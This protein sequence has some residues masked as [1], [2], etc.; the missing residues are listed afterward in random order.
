MTMTLHRQSDARF[1]GKR[2]PLGQLMLALYGLGISGAGLLAPA[3]AQAQAETAAAP[4][5]DIQEVVVTARKRSETLIEVPVSIQSFSDKDLRAAGV[6][7]IT[8]LTT[9]S[10][11]SFTSAQ[12]NGAQ[13]RAF[14]VMT[15]R[16]L[17]GELN[18]PWENSGGV[19]ID[20]I[21]IS[22]GVGSIGMNDVAR[23]EVL[24]GP[25]N[26]FFGR[27]TFG[28]AVNFITKNPSGSL[29]GSVNTM[30]DHH[31]SVDV[32]ATIEGPLA[33]DLA[34]GRLSF[35]SSNKA[36]RFRASDGGA[37]GAEST[38]FVTGTVYLTPTDD[39]WLRLRGHFQKDDDSSPATAM[40]SSAGNTSCTGKVYSGIDR[41]GNRVDYT[42]GT[43]YFCDGIPTLKSQGD[44]AI[45]ANTV[46]PAAAYAAFVNN[47]L[48]DPFLGTVPR[49]DHTGMRRDI[50][51]LSAQLGYALPRGMDLAVNLGFNEAG[52]YSIYDLDRTGVN[53][54][55]NAQTNY[56]KDMTLDARIS[57]D[58]KAALRALIGASYFKAT[59]QLSQL[60][61]NIGLGVI[62][63]GRNAGTFVNNVSTVPALY[64]SV[65][66]DITKTVTAS[67]ETRY[68]SDTVDFTNFANTS[69]TSNEKKNWLP[70]VSLRYKP[71][72]SLSTYV[73]L[74]S[75]VQPL[76]VN[77]G[78]ANASAAGK[79]YIRTLY[80][81]ADDF[82]PQPKLTSFEIGLKQRV[83]EKLIYALALYD[84]KWTDRLSITTL[85]NPAAC[86]TGTYS[87]P[88]CP[89]S[90]AGSQ[91]SVGN[92][93][94]LR[95]LELSIDSQLTPQLSAGAYIDVKRGTW[96]RFDSG[97]QSRFGSNGVRALTGDAVAFDGNHMARIPD[98][99]VAANATY[100]MGLGGGWDSYVRGDVTYV[101]KQWETDFNFTQ[102]NAY[103]RVDLRVGFEKAGASIEFFVRNLADDQNWTS[104][105]RSP[106]LGVTPLTSF[107]N[108]GLIATAQDA[109]AYGLRLRYAF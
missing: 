41:D 6:T 13:G 14:G 74:A 48:N 22:G 104:I 45:N 100:R 71:S 102:A 5:M 43:A 46:I 17:Q 66:Y 70:R 8:D 49:L 47:A 36:A 21:F 18:Y 9:K 89:L 105:T 84:Q 92:Q 50:Q 51:R 87:T 29:K 40:V 78:Y 42:P 26:A 53:N 73:T 12:G 72:A 15:F 69:T 24:K 37:L 54:L 1:P 20:G 34:T 63:P 91:V 107:S 81:S 103:S 64:G 95:G 52:Q 108:M 57:T 58:A 7:E 109:R 32:D 65:E 4:A 98:I 80:P 68:Q 59:Y 79:A 55:M 85:F 82:T 77:G 93:A 76:T 38:R 90:A 2:H 44:G 56:T 61:Y 62:A 101:G 86:G 83:S 27:S 39:L 94:R 23:V 96:D 19:F 28:G 31:G 60:D 106:N 25:Q 35:G 75:G 16:G 97:G 99:T 67:I 11:F 10:G 3:V 33:E 88:E 30:I